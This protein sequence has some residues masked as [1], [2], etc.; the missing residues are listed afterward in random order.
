MIKFMY[1]DICIVQYY[2]VVRHERYVFY[3]KMY[4]KW[5]LKYTYYTSNTWNRSLTYTGRRLRNAT[6]RI[7]KNTS[8]DYTGLRSCAEEGEEE[9]A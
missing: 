6:E 8:P 4:L 3:I 7:N 2:N 5:Y 9:N 1:V